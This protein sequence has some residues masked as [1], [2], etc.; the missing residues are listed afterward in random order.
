MDDINIEIGKLHKVFQEAMYHNNQNYS[1]PMITPRIASDCIYI[2]AYSDT[3][4][5]LE[6]LRPILEYRK[7]VALYMLDNGH[8]RLN[9]LTH[10]IRHLDEMVHKLLGMEEI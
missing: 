3:E 5:N 2:S 8:H 6:A 9:E 4:R 1:P 10:V 7:K